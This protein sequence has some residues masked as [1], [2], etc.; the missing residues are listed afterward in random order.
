MVEIKFV[1]TYNGLP[2]GDT[3]FIPEEE[4]ALLT[5]QDIEDMKEAR[6]QRWINH[7]NIASL[8]DETPPVEETPAPLE[9]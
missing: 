6:F 2:Y 5:E 4:Y 3:L 7:I 8:Q 9:P 1:K